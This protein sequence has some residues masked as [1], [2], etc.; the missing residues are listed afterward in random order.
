MKAYEVPT[1]SAQSKGRPIVNYIDLRGK[2]ITNIINVANLKEGYLIFLTKKGIIKKTEMKNFA[3]PR[4]GGIK[5]INLDD[6]DAV[7]SVLYTKEA[8]EDIITESNVGLAIRFRQ[9]DLSVL[10][11]TAKG[12]KSMNLRGTE[13]VV[14][15]E[16][17]KSGKTLFTI[18]ESG[19]GKRTLLSEYPTIR[20]AGRGVIDIKTDDRNGKVVTM[21]S[22]GEDDE[23]LLVTK[24]GKVIRT[25]VS[26]VRIIGRNT[27]GVRIINLES[28]DRIERAEIIISEDEIEE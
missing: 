26:D 8:T 20:R 5:A 10:G 17:A 12:V 24:K 21:K 16:L 23:L 22:V 28:G 2:D 11:R 25:S 13:E 15:L 19:Y 3:K 18:T 4:A 6:G 9:D 14:G 7:L 27:K 1:A